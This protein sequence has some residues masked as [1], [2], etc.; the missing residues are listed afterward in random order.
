MLYLIAKEYKRCITVMT[1]MIPTKE[2]HLYV[3]ALREC[4]SHG[5]SLKDGKDRTNQ[6]KTKTAWIG[7][8]AVDFP[9]VIRTL[10]SC[11]VHI[12]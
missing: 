11:D 3:P 10:K 7:N 6:S 2:V 5:N 4:M 9:V 8:S 12:K 1:R